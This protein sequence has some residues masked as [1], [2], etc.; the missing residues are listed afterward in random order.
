MYA[1]EETLGAGIV[2]SGVPRSQLYITTKFNKLAPGQS[3]K[4]LLQDQL[5]KLKVDYVDLYLIHTPAVFK[6]E[7]ELKKLWTE[8]E[9]LKKE[10]LTR[11][12][13]VSNFRIKD[14]EVILADGGAVPAINQ[15]NVPT[16]LP[17]LSL[18]SR[19]RVWLNRG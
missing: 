15:V 6:K 1:N 9:E 3:L 11:S 16:F 12:I 10:G 14:L 7:G 19:R 2:S 4:S 13:G 5:K 17:S 8:A 18:R